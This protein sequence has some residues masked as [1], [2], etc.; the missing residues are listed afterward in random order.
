MGFAEIK[1]LAAAEGVD[2]NHSGDGT[3]N[4]QPWGR[5]RQELAATGFGIPSRACGVESLPTSESNKNCSATETC[6]G[7]LVPNAVANGSQWVPRGL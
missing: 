1:K 7:S 5:R 6:G 2:H 3:S 4:P